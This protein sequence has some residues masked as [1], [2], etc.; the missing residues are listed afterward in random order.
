M[1]RIA[2]LKKRGEVGKRERRMSQKSILLG[3]PRCREGKER[4]ERKKVFI[5]RT[6]NAILVDHKGRSL[7]LKPVVADASK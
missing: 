5:A 2:G 4:K 6:S 1:E 7:Q 3:L